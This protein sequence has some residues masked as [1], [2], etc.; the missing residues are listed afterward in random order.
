[1]N[2]KP[3]NLETVWNDTYRETKVV[4]DGVRLFSAIHSTAGP[5]LRL[6]ITTY[7][8]SVALFCKVNLTPDQAEALSADLL[9]AANIKRHH[10]ADWK[11]HQSEKL[12]EGA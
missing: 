12:P 2:T 11:A 5:I 8:E 9:I 7:G 3:I 10:D 1:M 4:G 6:E